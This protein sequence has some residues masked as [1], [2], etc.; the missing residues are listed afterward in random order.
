MR[1]RAGD[2][3]VT[4]FDLVDQTVAREELQSPIDGDG[5]RPRALLGHA[6][7][8]VV[9]ARRRMVFRHA[10]EDIPA[11]AGEPRT[12]PSADKLG[13]GEKLCRAFGMIVARIEE[14]HGV[15]I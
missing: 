4:A 14:G 10:V 13:A 3:G 15:I 8:D 5:R 2:E 11:L 7:Y 12:T 9:S 1:A 6:L